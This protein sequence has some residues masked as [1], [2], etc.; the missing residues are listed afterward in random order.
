MRSPSLNASHLAAV[1]DAWPDAMRIERTASELR[2][3]ASRAALELAAGRTGI[4]DGL[5]AEMQSPS[6]TLHWNPAESALEPPA[7]R[8]LARYWEACPKIGGLPRSSLIDP[9]DLA[10]ALGYVM[11]M[12]P[13][14][15]S[16]DFR[17][18]VY[19]STIVEYSGVEMTGKCVWDIPVPQ[20]AAYFVATYKAVTDRRRPLFAHHRTHHH[21]QV[22]QWDR[23]VLPFVDEHGTVDR[24]LVGNVPSLRRP[25]RTGSDGRDRRAV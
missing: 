25:Q 11:L 13:V 14:E 12:E 9:L 7:L 15:R 10:P 17:Y 2:D 8:F 20:V 4:I 21:I 22:A 6:P 3:I 5:F 19:G 23:L 1:L 16:A 18:R 24:L